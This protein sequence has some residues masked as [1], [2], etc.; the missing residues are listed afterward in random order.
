M[1]WLMFFLWRVS[2][3]SNKVEE[4]RAEQGQT[5]PN[6]GSALL[7]KICDPAYPQYYEPVLAELCIHGRK[8]E[9]LM[10]LAEESSQQE[11]L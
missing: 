3:Q 5:K 8:I 10:S 6:Y 7:S 11:R 1:D 2:I 9:E 4:E